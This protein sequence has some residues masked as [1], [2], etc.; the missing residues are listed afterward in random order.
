MM[1]GKRRFYCVWK[2]FD[3]AAIYPPWFGEKKS[4]QKLYPKGWCARSCL[5]TRKFVCF[6]L[7]F[8]CV[9]YAVSSGSVSAATRLAYW[10]EVLRILIRIY[11][12]WSHLFIFVW[13]IRFVSVTIV[14]IIFCFCLFFLLR[15]PSAPELLE[16]VLW[17]RTALYCSD[18]L[19]WEQQQD[20]TRPSRRMDLQADFFL[21][22]TNGRKSANRRRAMYLWKI[23]DEIFP[24][25][26][27]YF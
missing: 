4:S 18:E 27:F 13:G 17:P 20:A 16:P 5:W 1:M 10:Y 12:R 26:P 15:E 8:S 19:M 24:D 6:I 7:S 25:A 23:L 2:V 22:T 9:Y 21:S 11:V 14:C 3:E